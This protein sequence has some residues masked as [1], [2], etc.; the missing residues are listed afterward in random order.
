MTH[1]MQRQAFIVNKSGLIESLGPRA[2]HLKEGV[3]VLRLFGY[4]SKQRSSF[5]LWSIAPGC[6]AQ[7]G[8]FHHGYEKHH[9]CEMILRTLQGDIGLGIGD[10]ELQR[11][12][13]RDLCLIPHLKKILDKGRI[14]F[15]NLY[16]TK[17]AIVF[18]AFGHCLPTGL[19][20]VRTPAGFIPG[21]DHARKNWIQATLHVLTEIKGPHS[22]FPSYLQI[23]LLRA[24]Q[25][26]GNDAQSLLGVIPARLQEDYILSNTS[27]Q[28]FIFTRELHQGVGEMTRHSFFNDKSRQAC[29]VQLW[30]LRPGTTEGMHIHEGVNNDMPSVG[31]L[32]EIYV[33]LAGKGKITLKDGECLELSPG[34][35]AIA[36][37]CVWHGVEAVG[38]KNFFML[39]AWGSEEAPELQFRSCLHSSR[40]YGGSPIPFIA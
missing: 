32:E 12:A 2:I 18:C 9:D 3:S 15:E 1:S 34:D 33:C 24:W 10:G 39:V 5:E 27:R 8:E 37:A 28:P 11:F 26:L 20:M 35:A 23:Q 16:S 25:K 13:F 31:N 21:R 38:D 6:T 19:P 7:W 17:P 36:P 4:E 30:D 14:V 22:K 40:T 29:T